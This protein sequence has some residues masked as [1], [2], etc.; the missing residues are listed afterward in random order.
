MSISNT[1][2]LSKVAVQLQEHTREVTCSNFRL[3][4]SQPYEE[5]APFEHIPLSA[6][7]TITGT[8]VSEVVYKSKMSLT[9]AEKLAKA[10]LAGD[11]DAALA[12]ADEVQMAYTKQEKF[13]SRK[14]LIAMLRYVSTECGFYNE[15]YVEEQ[16]DAILKK[17]EL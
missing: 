2:K 7:V 3:G 5:I 6:N 11:T 12:L 1:G 8:V 16:L 13:V 15:N 14:E 9:D 17:C 10:V 4:V